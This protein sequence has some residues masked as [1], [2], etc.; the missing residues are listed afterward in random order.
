MVAAMCHPSILA[1]GAEHLRE[2]EIRDRAVLEV[3]SRVVQASWMTLRHHVEALGPSRYVGV[4]IED[5]YGVDEICPA[6][7][8]RERYGDEAFDVVISTELLEHVRDWQVVAHNLKHVLK[9]G[10]S[11]LVTTRSFGFPHH[12]WPHDFWRF[13][14]D[15]MRA[16]FADLSIVAIERDPGDPGV[17]LKASKPHDFRERVPTT[18]MYSVILGR[19]ASSVSTL[20]WKAYAV[21]LPLQRT[22]RRL[23]PERPRRRISR[24]LGR[25]T[26][27]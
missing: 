2:S 13:E 17:L 26:S 5:G 27:E 23:V 15:D 16:V 20:Q 4:D 19:R 18:D 7:A 8:I 14:V 25:Q 12:G 24:L 1:F 22:F 9:S 11:L 10:G 3:G 21:T 6:E